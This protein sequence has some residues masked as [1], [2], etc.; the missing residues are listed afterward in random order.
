MIK[1]IVFLFFLSLPVYAGPIIECKFRAYDSADDNDLVKFVKFDI[2]PRAEVER[3]FKPYDIVISSNLTTLKIKIYLSD[4]L[5]SLQKIPLDNVAFLPL[6]VPLF[7][8]IKIPHT[9]TDGYTSIRYGCIK[10]F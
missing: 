8:D 7:G 6:G 2:L 3:T 4:S 9:E 5:I 1:K 10:I